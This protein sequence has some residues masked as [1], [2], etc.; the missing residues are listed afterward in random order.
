MV[1]NVEWKVAG[2][3]CTNCA[4]SIEKVLKSKGMQNVS[5]NFIGGNVSFENP[6]TTDL[7]TIEKEIDKLGYHVVNGT[8]KQNTQ[9]KK[10]VFKNHFQR[11]IFCLIFTIPLWLHMVVHAEILMNSWFQLVLTIPVF[12]VGMM[13]FGAS[14]WRSLRKGVPNM[15]V[16]VAVGA[17]AAFAYSLYG[18]IIGDAHNYMFYETTATIITLVFMGNWLEDRTVQQTQTALNSLVV[19]QQIQANMIVYDDQHNE[20]IM[21]VESEHLKTGDLILIKSGE[22]VP[23]DCK[24]LSGNASVDESIITGESVPVEKAA[25]EFLIGGSMVTDGNV[26]AYVT[27]V[28]KD[29]VLNKILQL[30]KDAQKDKP[31]MQQLADKISAIFIPAVLAIA[32]ICFLGNYFLASQSFSTSLLRSVAVLVIACPCAMGLA[33]PA[34][35]AVGLGR[36]AKHGILFRNARSLEVFK[37][38]RQIVFDKTG[39]LTTGEFS[40][41][42]YFVSPTISEEDFKKILFSMEKFSNHPIAKAITK[43]W[44]T[45]GAIIWKKT[46]EIKGIGMKAED[47]D[48]NIYWA[49]SYKKAQG[50]TDDLSHNLYLIK[51]AEVLGWLD[52]EDTLRPE[53]K[54]VIAQLQSKG[55]KTILL[56]GD[57]KEKVASIAKQLNIDEFFAEQTPE[58]KLNKISELNSKVPTA[59]VG[60]GINDAPALAKATIGV[61]LSDSSQIA[62]QTA[63]VVL[64]NHGLQNLPLALGL[65]KHTHLTI[66][67]N[68]FWAFAYNV[69]A[70]PVACFGLLIPAFAALAMGFSD[71]VLGFNSIKLRWK[72]VI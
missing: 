46:E 53:A 33:T 56:S 3:S 27:A 8:A 55:L 29:S 41:T 22:F 13:F 35:I 70:I 32:L 21:P 1:E 25:S 14:G 43:N 15:N 39:T 60:D 69:V 18:T 30:A 17:I 4:L 54:D 12:V 31:P 67:Q 45:P 68:L 23:M 42:N 62:I 71:V 34:A 52:I 5:V 20:H 59:M 7:Q 50:L 24:I 49:A 66:K 16:L 37:D 40:I 38:I 44:K 47:K 26:K 57:S 48:G 51:N 11:F 72:K 64:M 61:S 9:A 28:G 6:G 58:Q 10:K 63:Q 2:M 19:S 36:A 65:G